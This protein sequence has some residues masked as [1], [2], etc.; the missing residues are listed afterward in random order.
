MQCSVGGPRLVRP[1][2]GEGQGPRGK[3]REPKARAGSQVCLRGDKPRGVAADGRRL[4]GDW[5]L[6][7]LTRVQQQVFQQQ[8]RLR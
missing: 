7:M 1:G 5:P 3:P 4:A 2:A 8:A 6:G